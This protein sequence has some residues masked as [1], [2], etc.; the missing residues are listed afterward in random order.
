MDD[1]GALATAETVAILRSAGLGIDT[2]TTLS[3][4][5]RLVLEVK[6]SRLIAKAVPVRAR[7]RLALEVAVSHHV[8]ALSGPGTRPASPSGPFHGS[9][10][11]ISV[12]EPIVVLGTPSER[13]IC[14]AYTELRA[15]LD[16]FSRA[17][18][19]FRE[20][21]REANSLVIQ[22]DL[23]TISEPDNSFVRTSFDT[24]L[25][26]L[27]SFRWQ[28][29][30]L[31]GDPHSGNAVLTPDGP[32]WCDLESVCA[33]PIE[34]DLSAL[35]AC[36]SAMDHDRDLLAVLTT[37]R[38]LC[39]V[40]WCASKTRPAPPEAEAIV[41]HLDVLKKEAGAVRGPITA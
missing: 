36:S 2:W 7:D 21:I 17:L 5:N 9:T 29:R 22:T 25:R 19:D 10:V 24:A 32:L 14:G 13:S 18:P 40:T 33:G 4:S 1:W 31:H 20:A 41:H 37:L 6:P 34:W 11:A 12:W 23:P 39:V 30:V 28:P 38:R 35:P 3:E 27:A 8:V 16:S 15:C 26:R